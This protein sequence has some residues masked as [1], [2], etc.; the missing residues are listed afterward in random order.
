MSGAN[1][2]A[3]ER[4]ERGRWQGY[5]D[6]QHV[7]ISTAR[8]I[9]EA[10]GAYARIRGLHVQGAR[11]PPE[12]AATAHGKMLAPC[13]QLLPEI[14]QEA[15]GDT[16]EVY[17]QILADWSDDGHLNRLSEVNLVESCP[18]WLQ[19]MMIQLRRAGWELGYL[20]AGKRDAPEPEDPVEAEARSMFAE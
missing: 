19:T 6:Y 4:G 9:D 10:L 20:K 8:A 18:G 13:M 3:G 2:D 1:P 5:S 14:E 17:E 15:D 7:S 11:I 16:A 12:V